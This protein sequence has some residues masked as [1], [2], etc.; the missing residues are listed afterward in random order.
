MKEID[1]QNSIRLELS[2]LGGLVLRLNNG[3]FYTEDGRPIKSGLPKGTSDLLYVG[4][5]IIAFMEVKTSKGKPRPE[6]LRFIEKI[7]SLGHKAGIVRSVEDALKLI[8]E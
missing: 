1:I 3:L 8:N 5:D 2:K 6:Q 4:N 7:K